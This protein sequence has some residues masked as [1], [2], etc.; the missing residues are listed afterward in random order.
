VNLRVCKALSRRPLSGTWYRA[1]ELLPKI[2]KD[3]LATKQTKRWEGRFTPARLTTPPFALL[4]L[5][6]NQVLTLRE[7]EAIYGPLIPGR[8]VAVPDRPLVIINVEVQLHNVVDLTD[9]SQQQLLRLEP[10]E[11]SG[12]WESYVRQR[13]LAP[14]HEL[15]KALFDVPEVE[16]FLVPSAKSFE[17]KN[18]NVFPAKLR[19]GSLVRFYDPLSQK[20]CRI[21]GKARR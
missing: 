7:V 18:L 1:L 6:E 10:Q 5:C 17:E 11:L 8:I 20:H 14:T 19:K 21:K 3:P 9:P 12:N 2:L 16:A 13:Q 4:Y 15:A